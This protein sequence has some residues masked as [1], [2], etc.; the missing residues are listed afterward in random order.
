MSKRQILAP[1]QEPSVNIVL[2]SLR[3]PPLDI[4]LPG[5]P[6]STGLLNLKHAVA[7]RANIPVDKLRLLYKKKPCSDAKT[8]KDLVPAGEKDVEFSVMVIG[9]VAA[10]P[11]PVPAGSTAA[12]S[13]EQVKDSANAPT[14]GN[15]VLGTEAFWQD[16]NR[17]LEP[18]LTD[19]AQRENVAR[20]FR[21][22]WARQAST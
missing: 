20:V 7:E 12:V 13:P 1:G 14:N 2:K 15:E 22:A 3:N 17:F 5:Q 10:P 8:I 9:G 11:A 18:R 19:Q 4:T 6:V 21:D 16:L